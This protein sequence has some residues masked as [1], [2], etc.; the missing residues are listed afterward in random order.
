LQFDWIRLFFFINP[1]LFY[2]PIVYFVF[3]LDLHQM[4][5]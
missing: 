3:S 2:L 5:K 4:L 1:S